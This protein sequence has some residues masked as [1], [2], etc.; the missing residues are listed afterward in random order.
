AEHGQDGRGGHGRQVSRSEPKAS[1]VHRTR[2][3][4]PTPF[5]RLALEDRL[6]AGDPLVLDGATG[7]ELERRGVATRLPL[8]SAAPLDSDPELGY[9]IHAAHVARGVGGLWS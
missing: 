9:R 3:Y 7:T 1:E 5:S 4:S 2:E 6:R 8:W